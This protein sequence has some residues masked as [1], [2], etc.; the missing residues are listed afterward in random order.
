MSEVMN[1]RRRFR[2]RRKLIIKSGINPRVNQ[3][4]LDN[5]KMKLQRNR[6]RVNARLRRV[7]I[8]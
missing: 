3:R 7:Q 4:G 2:E 1:P 8:G 5:A 6:R